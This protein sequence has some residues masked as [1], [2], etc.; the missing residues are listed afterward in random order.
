MPVRAAEPRDAAACAAILNAWID[1]TDW[2]PRVHTSEDV[3]AYYAETAFPNRR[4]WVAGDPVAGFM[5]ID[6]GEGQITALYVATPGKGLGRAFVDLAK[7]LHDRL[8]LRTFVANARA[9]RFYE[10]EGFVVVRRTAGDNEGGLPDLLYRWE[11]AQCSG[12]P[13]SSPWS[14]PLWL[15][16]TP[17]A[18]P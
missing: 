14:P 3:E 9:R 10:R 1:A 17:P 6:R 18:F 4:V 16:G 8:E 5:V 12:S 15:F 2:M 11:G 13:R 7:S